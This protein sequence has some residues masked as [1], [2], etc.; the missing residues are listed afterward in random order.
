MEDRN[1]KHII[2]PNVREF[3][4][5][6][7][8]PDTG[9]QLVRLS[10]VLRRL[11]PETGL[12]VVGCLAVLA[13]LMRAPEWTTGLSYMALGTLGFMMMVVAWMR[14]HRDAHENEAEADPSAR[15]ANGAG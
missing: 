2:T 3:D 12:Y 1:S 8:V 10:R 5:V 15:R 4:G 14:R 13:V 9:S 11:P 7:V 6:F